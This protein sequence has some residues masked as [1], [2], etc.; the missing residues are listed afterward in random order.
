[1]NG[2]L[3]DGDF[4]N[5]WFWGCNHKL[6]I[7]FDVYDGESILPVQELALDQ[8]VNK[9]DL[10][11]TVR[12]SFEEYIKETKPEDVQLDTLENLRKYVAPRSIFIKRPRNS[13]RIIAILCEYVYDIEDG[14]AIVFVNEQ[15]A[16]VGKQNIIL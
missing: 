14:I 6:E 3:T 12:L 5:L 10:L 1:M 4:L 15:L 13:D 8:F 11:D 2:E 9:I 16:K 7:V